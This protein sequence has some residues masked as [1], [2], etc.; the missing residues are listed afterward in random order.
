[1]GKWTVIVLACAMIAGDMC[2]RRTG[3]AEGLE[4][5]ATAHRGSSAATGHRK[6]TYT[7][8]A[9]YPRFTF[10]YP[11]QYR[12]M[13]ED[14]CYMSFGVSEN[15]KPAVVVGCT[16]TGATTLDDAIAEKQ[17]T[18]LAGRRCI[19]GYAAVAVRVIA[20]SIV[21]PIGDRDSGWI[22]V[23]DG[24]PTPG[25]SGRWAIVLPDDDLVL[26]TFHL[27]R[28]CKR[29]AGDTCCHDER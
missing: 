14:I 10:Q 12:A 22:M 4:S 2:S 17:L 23:V 16:P 9:P 25:T 29:T 20:D 7:S 27:T 18:K 3:R 24:A 19:D 1:M 28:R 6:R 5:P 26:S 15:E 13:G 21:R 11:S 8:H